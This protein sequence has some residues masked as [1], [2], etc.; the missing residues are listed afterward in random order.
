[1]NRI[2]AN[3]LGSILDL[4]PL[5][6]IDGQILV[7]RPQGTKGASREISEETADDPIIVR[8]LNMRWV[9]VEPVSMAAVVPTAPDAPP[10]PPA[11]PESDAPP[12]PSS[13]PSM[14]SDAPPAPPA[15]H[16]PETEPDALPPPPPAPPEVKTLPVETTIT[17]ETPVA[18]EPTS[19]KSRPRK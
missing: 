5:H 1:M 13:T 15:P 6:G 19:T 12:A 9:D 8:V 4:S 14:E 3:K 16:A 18:P 7:L 10:A 11:P 2:I 17:S